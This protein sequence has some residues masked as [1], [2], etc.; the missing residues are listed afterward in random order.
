MYTAR[1]MAIG[2]GA[3]YAPYGLDDISYDTPGI[4]EAVSVEHESG[5]A[6]RVT[7]RALSDGETR[8]V[9]GDK[10]LSMYW[11][12]RVLNG[13][14]FEGGFNFSGW[15]SIHVSFC[16]VLAVLSVLFASAVVSLMRRSWFGYEMVA[17]GGGFLF[18]LFQ[19]V[20][21]TYLF[22]NNSLLGFTDEAYLISYMAD[23]F[24]LLTLVPLAVLAVLV[25]ISNI[26]LIRHEG[27]R[28]TNL[29]GVALSIVWIIAIGVWYYWQ[30]IGVNLPLPRAAVNIVSCLVSI[31]I[32]NGECLLLSTMICAWVASRRTPKH[33]VDYLV[34]LGCGIRAD[35]TPTP[36][37][38][39]RVDRAYEFDVA[40]T[41]AG[42]KPVTFVP[43]GGKGSDEIIS[44]AQSMGNYLSGKGVS[45]ERI[46]LE[47]RSTTTRENMLYSRQ[48]IEQHAGCDVSELSVA[49]STTNYHVFRGYVFAHEA[50]MAVEGMGSKT[51]YY[52][53]PNAFLREFAGLLVAQWKGILQSLLFI[54]IIYVLAEYIL[55]YS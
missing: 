51:K 41:A 40:R 53:W 27:R 48:V 43:S 31:A 9:F 22:V 42:D 4:V 49:F 29:L 3:T 5:G 34:V 20:L 17:C 47:N 24:V 50:G 35:G 19:C 25:S 46:A 8:V 18:F 55:L 37:L 13:A 26:A 28:L 11:Q 12:M 30:L 1:T 14:I 10:R 52:F 36:L 38:A 7:F 6:A 45:L 15:E 33:A 32:V 23:Y 21:F 2:D 44:E 16:I 54:S 39:G